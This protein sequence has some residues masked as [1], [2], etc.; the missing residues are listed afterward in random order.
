M[1]LKKVYKKAYIVCQINVTVHTF[2]YE[3]SRFKFQIH[4]TYLYFLQIFLNI[5]SRG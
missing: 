4:T 3:E 1:Y 5:C 2:R